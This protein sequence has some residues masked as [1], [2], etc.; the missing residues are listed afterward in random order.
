MKIFKHTHTHTSWAVFFPPCTNPESVCVCVCVWMHVHLCVWSNEHISLCLCKYSGLLWG[1]IY[2]THTHTNTQPPPPSPPHINACIQLKNLFNTVTSQ[3][4]VWRKGVKEPGLE[5]ATR[6]Y[7]PW[8]WW[9][10]GSMGSSR[11]SS[12]SGTLDR[13]PRW[14]SR[15]THHRSV[16]LACHAPPAPGS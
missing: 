11:H 6:H 15:S 16:I 9:C 8:S 1:A 10:C 14:P 12:P 3:D 13:C 4:R 5:C 7:W 2:N